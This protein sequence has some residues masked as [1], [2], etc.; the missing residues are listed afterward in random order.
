MR[1]RFLFIGLFLYTMIFT[2]FINRHANAQLSKNRIFGQLS[3]NMRLSY[4]NSEDEYLFVPTFEGLR[5]INPDNFIVEKEINLKNITDFA[6]ISNIEDSSKP[7]NDLILFID[8]GMLPSLMVYSLDSMEKIWSFTSYVSGYSEDNIKTE[9]KITVLDYD[10]DST[11]II[12]VSG[13][14]LYHLDIKTGKINWKYTYSDNIWSSAFIGDINN[15]SVNDI[16]ISV[17]PSKILGLDGN[18]G[19]ILWSSDVAKP[20]KVKNNNKTLGSI[21]TN[22]W[23]IQYFNNKII[24]SGE[25]GAIYK[26]NPSDGKITD[27]RKVMA[28]LP[29]ALVYQHYMEGNKVR[30]YSGMGLYKNLN[31][32]NIGEDLLV[33]V[34]E[35]N[36]YN[37]Y[38]GY[39]PSVYL[40][41]GETFNI[42]WQPE[43]NLDQ[44]LS[45]YYDED[46]ILLNDGKSIKYVTIGDNYDLTDITFTELFSVYDLLSPVLYGDS[47]FIYTEGI[48]KI[49]ITDKLN[50]GIDS[51]ITI[52]NGY[53][54]EMENN[55]V[56][57]L[58]YNYHNS[59]KDIKDYYALEISN[60]SMDLGENY[61]NHYL[62]ADD[63]LFFIDN[64]KKLNSIEYNDGLEINSYQIADE[65]MEPRLM[66]KCPDINNDGYDDIL[67]NYM[68]Q[69]QII[70]SQNPGEILY[71]QFFYRITE[72]KFYQLVLPVFNKEKMQMYLLSDNNLTIVS[73][74][75]EFQ[76]TIEEE[77]PFG[78]YQFWYHPS[79]IGYDKDFD[80]DGYN[81]FVLRIS[82]D[83]NNRALILYTGEAITGNIKVNWDYGLYPTYEDFN[84]DGKYEIIM[85]TSGNDE[86]GTWHI[87]SEIVNPF[88][89]INQNGALF[90]RRF[91]EGNELTYNSQLKPLAIIDDVTGDGIKDVMVLVDRWK[92]TYLQIYNYAE[93]TIHDIIP[94]KISY[95]NESDMK[96]ANIGSPGALLDTFV[97]DGHQ[98]LLLTVIEEDYV[99]TKIMTMDIQTVKNI[100]GR[101]YDYELND[102][103]FIYTM[104]EEIINDFQFTQ[105]N[106]TINLALDKTYHKN[107]LTLKWESFDGSLYNLYLNGKLVE[108]TSKNEA[109]LLL[110]EG[111]NIIGIGVIN[112]EGVEHIS[113]YTINCKLA[114][115][116]YLYLII[117]ILLLIIVFLL[118]L[119]KNKYVR[120]G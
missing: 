57:K 20:Y 40:V 77:V 115:Q 25:D 76:I 98:Y 120:R 96:D 1:K 67:I 97:H 27:S 104:D 43:K 91:Y 113:Y 38:K 88:V 54:T 73:L 26:I 89:N 119:K 117:T 16:A 85:T 74:D 56:Y 64:E 7:N 30:E 4:I 118:P 10:T 101:I 33:T 52:F 114:N 66:T 39:N 42:I 111:K 6:V 72:D 108:I 51:K 47:V 78:N 94:V 3:G 12:L 71:Q 17:Q 90:S 65:L 9:R 62:I 63:K 28:D 83:T 31:V 86:K 48:Y 75:D 61:F 46:I 19:S 35:A 49:N 41:D 32:R 21:M 58:Y 50:P 24:A 15:D 82:E 70:N 106:I 13:Y 107:D 22:I 36:R 105:E 103:T 45:V 84:G 37:D 95:I 100:K 29:Q 116:Q 18:S 68:D 99:T 55:R 110:R 8:E 80:H 102:D 112:E 5:L 81:D 53:D 93:K 60:E 79:N 2:I 44:L 14:S 23:D 59:N 92:E 69:F 11:S 109:D 34:F 87:A